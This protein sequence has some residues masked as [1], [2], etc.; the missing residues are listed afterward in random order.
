MSSI[1]TSTSAASP[2]YDA[3][4]DCF[5]CSTLS[6]PF[7]FSSAL[8]TVAFSMLPKYG[9]NAAASSRLPFSF[10][11]TFSG[12]AVTL[13]DSSSEPLRLSVAVS[14]TGNGLDRSSLIC[15]TF[16]ASGAIAS[17]TGRG[18]ERSVKFAFASFTFSSSI[19]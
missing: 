18:V 6:S 3:F 17:F 4:V 2:R 9:S 15:R 14:L 1:R 7:A 16:S 5:A 12:C 8:A 11:P 10:R 19:R 13:P